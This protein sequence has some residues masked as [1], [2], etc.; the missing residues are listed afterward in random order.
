M[1][2]TRSAGDSAA[3]HSS[4]FCPRKIKL[5]GHMIERRREKEI[6][7]KQYKISSV[8]AFHES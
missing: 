8:G 2:A 4:I 5:H 7:T 6:K 1:T 3:P